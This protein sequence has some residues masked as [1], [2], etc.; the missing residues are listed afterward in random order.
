MADV[1]ADYQKAHRVA[2]K[3]LVEAE[4]GHSANYHHDLGCLYM[5]LGAA[6]ERNRGVHLTAD[7]VTALLRLDAAVAAATQ[8]TCRKLL[9]HYSGEASHG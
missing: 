4:L 3:R 2:S 7:E 5:R 1:L 9:G 8:E 6:H